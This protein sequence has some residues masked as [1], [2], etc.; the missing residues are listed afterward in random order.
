MKLLDY[1]R[2]VGGVFA[3]AGAIVLIWRGYVEY[4][5]IILSTMLGFF[6]GEQNGKRQT[7]EG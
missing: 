4:G 3:G 5:V 6:V 2:I 7:N 1:A